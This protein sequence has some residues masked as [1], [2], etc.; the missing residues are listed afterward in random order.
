MEVKTLERSRPEVLAP[1]GDLS[2]LF[3]AL[4][5]GADAVYFGIDGLFNARAKSDGVK[6]DQLD[7]V[8]ER[9]HFADAKAL[10]TMNTLIFEGEL[11]RVALMIE[12]I[13]GAGVDALIVQDPAVALL[14][15]EI[16]PTLEVHASTQMT[17]SSPEAARFAQRLGVTRV[18]VPRELTISQIA[19]FKA[20]SDLELEVF[21]H[22]A[23][24]MS[25]SGQCLTSEAWG[26]RSA[27][28][29]Q[30]AQS[31]R[32][33]YQ[34][35]VDGEE[36]DLGEIKYLLSPRDLA[37]VRAVESLMKIGV[38]CFKI[39]GRYKGPSYVQQAVQTYRSWIEATAA[40]E[41]N[42]QSKQEEL[43]EQ[44][45]G[46]SL[47]YSRG[48]SDGFLGGSD[49]QSLVEGRFPKHRGVFLGYVT[50]FDDSWIKLSTR[51]DGRRYNDAAK[52]KR[53]DPLPLYE[54]S[55]RLGED[56]AE[57]A[58]Q[59]GP[60]LANLILEPGMGIVFDDGAPEGSEVGGRISEVRVENDTSLSFRLHKKSSDLSVIRSV[61]KGQRVWVNDDPKRKQS[62]QK[63]QKRFAEQE[64]SNRLRINLKVSGKSGEQLVLLGRLLCQNPRYRALSVEVKSEVM[65]SSNLERPLNEKLLRDKLGAFGGTPFT[66]A[67]LEL[68]LADH[69]GLPV[70]ALKS[71]R[72][73]LV[74][75]LI[76]EMSQRRPHQ[77]I[78]PG[79]LS[80][81]S[82][83]SESSSTSGE[84]V[85][86]VVSMRS[87][88]LE[89]RDTPQLVPLCRTMEQLE[90]V[91][92]CIEDARDL[93]LDDSRGQVSEVELDWMEFV[94][95]RQ[96]VERAR[97]AGL[98]VTIATVR[99]QKPGE[100]G[101]DR[102]IESLKPDGVLVRHWGAL[103][104]FASLPIEERPTLHGDFSLNLTNSLSAHHALSYGL[105]TITAA[106]DL[107]VVQLGAL[108]KHFPA[109]SSAVTIHHH[110]PT[111]HTEHCVYAHLLSNGRDYKTCGRPCEAH[112][113]S[114]KDHKGM[115][116][117]VLVDVEC[118][119]TVFN[120]S[121]QTAATLFSE[122][123]D[124]R[125]R[126]LR[127]EFVWEDR[128][129]TSIV[130]KSYQALLRDEIS[131]RQAL[132]R[133]GVH[134]Q[135]GLTTGTME[136]AQ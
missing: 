33:P 42:S 1:A 26:G 38:E 21:V 96:A 108:L 65:L 106:H 44:L 43:A 50:D 100:A 98:R 51:G 34:L 23:L 57:Q 19:K 77:I 118:R 82:L 105:S 15:R 14:A 130:L 87:E 95:L 54:S 13:A 12:R 63:S 62:A 22:G 59:R 86:R 72:R 88:D 52:G 11:N 136:V 102:R 6:S 25:W 129:Q 61:R 85:D 18:V 104:H 107:D 113:I 119:N 89:E 45:T 17:I 10:V 20:E 114:L 99:V 116:H 7:E 109:S 28:R 101:Y 127:L 41:L 67:D 64:A 83:K 78:K 60:S 92:S 124:Q 133:L 71:L 9:C 4:D 66:L 76:Y 115:A 74:A 70:S 84:S 5:A 103:T 36:R 81:A 49:H 3:A 30:C 110:I 125:I 68:D 79:L 48:F 128:A 73:E 112:R 122:L 135:F 94:G 27:N 75:A 55:E 31:C 39:E 53:S 93:G 16:A 2:S 120:A 121:A 123:C 35:I 29:G 134:E 69:C 131:S 56:E 40:K 111:F 132:E 58:R 117:P 97:E 32:M 80:L 37:G 47:A 90:A 8:V 46:L 24:C 126:R 91:I